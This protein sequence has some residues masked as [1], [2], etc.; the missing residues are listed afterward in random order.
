MSRFRAVLLAV[1]CLAPL[2]ACGGG[3]RGVVL[4]WYVKEDSS[5]AYRQAAQRCADS[6]AGRYR[7]R[8]ESLPQTTD[9]QRELLVRRLAA[10]DRTVDIMGMDVIWTAEFAEAGWLRPW[11]GAQAAQVSA[12]VLAGPLATAR[13]QGRLWAAPFTSNTELLWYRRSQ[14]PDPPT[15][16]DQLLAQAAA[17]PR[18]HNEVA[19]QGGRYEGYTVWVNALLASAGAQLVA[20]ADRPDRARAALADAPARQALAVI[21]R[22]ATSP[23]AAAGLSVDTEVETETAMLSGRAAF[24]L[25]YASLYAA[26]REQQP[27]QLADLGW[28]R[29]PQVVPGRPSRPPLGGINLGISA[30]SPHPAQAFDAAACLRSATSQQLAATRGGIPPT[31]SA[32]Y[33]DP[34]V[35]REFPFAALMRLCIEQAAP[36]PATPAYS[37]V[38]L[39]VQQVLHPPASVN[40]DR[41][42][43]E[44]RR[45]IDAALASKALL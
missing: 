24:S 1:L 6:S 20:D 11:T 39:A 26:V 22:V 23:V 10:R 42:V 3:D 14:T 32:V 28:T 17:L 45:T 25:N 31:I 19:V 8:V 4:H 40:P 9:T 27:A 36:R 16:W 18:G 12:G 13:Y 30:Y 35:V 41:D 15:T 37:D 44:L 21:R 38:S 29:Y 33:D 43:P 34:A 2:T 5:G 7:I